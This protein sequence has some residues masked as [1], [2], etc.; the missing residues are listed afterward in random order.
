MC[1]FAT[2]QTFSCFF[3]FSFWSQTHQL[4]HSAHYLRLKFLIE[5]KMQHYV[6]KPEEDIYELVMF[7]AIVQVPS[8][9]DFLKIICVPM[10]IVVGGVERIRK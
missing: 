3:L 5:N 7:M 2:E 1:L 4:D 10:L 6:P 9:G 8:V